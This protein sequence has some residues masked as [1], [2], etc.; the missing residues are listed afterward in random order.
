MDRLEASATHGGLPP[1]QDHVIAPVLR[2]TPS[3]ATEIARICP[4]LCFGQAAKKTDM[5]CM[6]YTTCTIRAL[7]AKL[8]NAG[9]FN[10][11]IICHL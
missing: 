3:H 6:I 5:T 4:L 11:K 1:T 8:R 2:P 10:E 7:V 9:V